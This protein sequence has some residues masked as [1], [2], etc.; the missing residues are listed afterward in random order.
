MNTN[1]VIIILLI[2]LV[3]ASVQTVCASG[4]PG[5]K[6][7]SRGKTMINFFM[8]CDDCDL[9]FVRQQL[10]FVSFVRDPKLGDVQLLVTDSPTGSGGRKYYL[11]F[12]GLGSLKGEDFSFEYFS[13]PSETDDDLRNGLL[14]IFKVG[15]ASYLIQSGIW[16]N[17][18]IQI[19][20][21]VHQKSAQ[22]HSDPWRK[23]VF[24]L[25][26]GGDLE[27]EKSQNEY[28]IE[29]NGRVDKVTEQWKTRLEAGYEVNRENFWDYEEKITTSQNEKNLSGEFVKSVSSR[30]SLAF[31]SKYSSSTYMNIEHSVKGDLGIEYNIFNWDE[32][33]SRVFTIGYRL[34]CRTYKYHKE[35][36]YDK[37]KETLPHHGLQVKLEMVQPWGNI[38]SSLEWNSFLNDLSKNRLTLDAD[39]SVRLTKKLS[40]F[41]KIQG[42]LIHDQLYLVKGEATVEDL[43]LKRRKLATTYGLDGKLGIRFTFGSIFNNVVNE[44]F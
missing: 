29:T 19:K 11:D 16:E 26:A 37:I 17:V 10:P 12:I 43:L 21:K 23:W 30:W 14:E 27:K 44:R 42:E 9:N 3:I 5:D 24:R 7:T 40:F 20:E 35:T 36:I 25:E 18:D 39:V 2:H 41:G 34:G 8:D 28:T 38:E 1:R 13:A 32:S 31:F 4:I 22:L 15:V 33:N 6:V